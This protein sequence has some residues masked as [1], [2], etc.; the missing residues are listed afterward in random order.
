MTLRSA[1]RRGSPPAPRSTPPTPPRA[2][3]DDDEPTSLFAV[4][5]LRDAAAATGQ[6]PQ[7]ATTTTRTACSRA[8]LS[9]PPRSPSP[10][11]TTTT[12]TRPGPQRPPSPPRP[13]S[14]RG[15]PSSA[16]ATPTAAPLDAAQLELDERPLGPSS[17]PRDGEPAEQADTDDPR[18]R[19]SPRRRSSQRRRRRRRELRH[20]RLDRHPPRRLD[21]LRCDRRGRLRRRRRGLGRPQTRRACCVDG[22]VDRRRPNPERRRRRVGAADRAV[23][24]APIPTDLG[25]AFPL[26]LWSDP[27]ELIARE[28]GRYRLKPLSRG[29]VTRVYARRVDWSTATARSPCACSG[30]RTRRPSR[31]PASSSTRPSS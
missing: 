10:P 16:P 11:S 7:P 3:A 5:R 30:R 31:A 20:R 17:A 1:A 15:G 26:D 6:Q 14:S 29:M 9:P 23:G 12:T 27:D 13:P 25:E 28:L 24:L 4:D 2:P 21:G 19:W 22:P 8:P 18:R